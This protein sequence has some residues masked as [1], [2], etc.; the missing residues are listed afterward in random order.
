MNKQDETIAKA[1]GNIPKE[2]G[3]TIDFSFIP[4]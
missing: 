2:V 4:T 1:Y 3:Y